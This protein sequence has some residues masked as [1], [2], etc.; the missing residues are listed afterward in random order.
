MAHRSPAPLAPRAPFA[1][2][3]AL[4]PVRDRASALDRRQLLRRLGLGLAALP[5]VS[6]CHDLGAGDGPDAATTTGADGGAPSSWARGGTAAM[7][8][9]A[10]YP[11]PF[12]GAATSCAL[13]ATVTEGP[14][15]TQT[16]LDREDV[17]EGWAGLPVRLALQIVDA[18]CAAV[19]GAQVKIW[20][21]NLAGSYSGATPN[22][23]MCLQQQSYASQ[24]FFRGARTTAADG[25]V[26]FDTCFPG[27]YR[28]RAVHIHVQI[29]RNGTT[30]KVAQ[31]FFPESLT[32]E[33]FA[34][35]PDYRGYGPP[36][37]TFAT[38]NVIATIPAAQRERGIVD[39]AWMSDGALLASKVITVL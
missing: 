16:T 21:T 12:G 29:S 26:Y 1:S 32:Q 35:H 20:H 39:H 9:K 33:I 34:G 37:T 38:D 17:S 24:D 10:S 7:T 11:N 30:Y 28:G 8:A 2:L 3:A 4:A 36:D 13:I 31:L 18:S 14:C 22:P 15:T 23:T 19:A 27:W 6:A 5:L 25:T